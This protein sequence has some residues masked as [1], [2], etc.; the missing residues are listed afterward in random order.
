MEKKVGYR[1]GAYICCLGLECHVY[2]A[3]AR[4]GDNASKLEGYEWEEKG[5]IFV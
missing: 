5:K 4:I 1:R 3:V 2:S